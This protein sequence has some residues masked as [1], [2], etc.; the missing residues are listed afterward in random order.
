VD[1]SEVTVLGILSVPR[2]S[3]ELHIVSSDKSAVVVHGIVVAYGIVVVHGVAVVG[4]K[5]VALLQTF[6]SCMCD[7]TC[8]SN[9]LDRFPV[10]S[11]VVSA[12]VWH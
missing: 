6:R 2:T 1:R 3:P 10:S 7:K 8:L 5:L 12:H 11:V 4:Y 9:S